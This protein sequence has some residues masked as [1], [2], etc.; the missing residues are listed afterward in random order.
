MKNIRVISKAV[1]FN[2][3]SVLVLKRS[4]SAKHRPLEW[5]LPGGYLEENEELTSGCIREIKEETGLKM[6]P[7]NLYLAHAQSQPNSL[8]GGDSLLIF[9]G[10]TSSVDIKLSHEH[11][12]FK[13]VTLKEAIE[14]ETHP[15]HLKALKYIQDN[16]LI[17]MAV[18]T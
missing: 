14:T 2:G 5:D 6:Q 11:S 17:P 15:L 7:S 4:A 10:R 18:E 9:I 1:I 16:K 13:W 8:S 12:N 3:D